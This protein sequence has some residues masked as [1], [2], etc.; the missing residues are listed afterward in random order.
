MSQAIDAAI[1]VTTAWL[2]LTVA[3]PSLASADTWMQ[4]NGLSPLRVAYSS[5]DTAPTTSGGVIINQGGIWG[6]NAAHIWVQALNGTTAISV[7]LA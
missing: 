3:Y 5:L 1:P 2:D 4:N 6:G 7:G